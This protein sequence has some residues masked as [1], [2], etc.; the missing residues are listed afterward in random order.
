MRQFGASGTEGLNRAFENFFEVMR[1]QLR[2]HI[3]T[4][5]MDEI[6]AKEKEL[7]EYKLEMQKIRKA[8]D[9]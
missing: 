1:L 5:H 8:C 2:T 4:K 3:K 6:T 9:K 7:A